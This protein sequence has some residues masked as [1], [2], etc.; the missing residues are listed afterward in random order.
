MNNQLAMWGY[1]YFTDLYI[2]VEQKKKILMR[3]FY[4][5]NTE[6]RVYAQPFW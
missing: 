3:I 1:I 5:F 6:K 2:L 4:F